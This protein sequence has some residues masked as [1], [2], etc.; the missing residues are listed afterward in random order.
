MLT[1]PGT[2]SRVSTATKSA[3][4]AGFVPR[5]IFLYLGILIVRL[6]CAWQQ[7]IM[8]MIAGGLNI[9]VARCGDVLGTILYDYYDSF[10]VCVI[11]ITVVYD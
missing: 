5:K 9:I 8:L 7:G 2:G 4:L 11:A 6:R 1:D 3:G 10:V